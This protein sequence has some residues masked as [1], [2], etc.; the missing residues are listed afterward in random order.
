MTGYNVI[1]AILCFM[2]RREGDAAENLNIRS[3]RGASSTVS[4]FKLTCHVPEYR[5]FFQ[6]VLP[7]G[8]LQFG[9][10]NCPAGRPC[11]I[12]K[13]ASADR[14]GDRTRLPTAT[15]SGRRIDRPRPACQLDSAAR[16][17]SLKNQTVL[18][19]PAGQF[20][21]MNCTRVHGRSV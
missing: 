13:P 10:S 17:D 21:K 14:S 20:E 7:G 4:F 11:P 12:D 6:T 1:F 5:S 3:S 19:R 2:D 16:Q 15:S 9:F 8:L 18:G